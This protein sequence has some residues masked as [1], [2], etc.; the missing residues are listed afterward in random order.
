MD[1][2]RNVGAAFAYVERIEQYGVG[3]RPVARLGLWRSGSDA[4]DEGVSSM[5]LETQTD[6]RAVA[7]DDDLSGYDAIILAGGRCLSAE[8]GRRLAGF[9]GGVLILGEGGL[10]A[11]DD[12][13]ALDAEVEYLG[14]GRYDID[15]LCAGE[16][17]GDGLVGSPFLCYESGLRTATADGTE[18]LARIREPHFSRTYGAYCGHLNTPYGPSDAA[19]PGAVRT[20]NRVFLAHNLDGI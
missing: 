3:G 9:E 2:Y 11:G 12:R 17:V 15:Y 18:V 5:L 6:Y 10:V 13:F 1:T 8:D 14:P 20:G 19:H 16:P 7:D 4:D